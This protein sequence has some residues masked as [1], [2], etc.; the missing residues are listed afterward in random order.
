MKTGWNGYSLLVDVGLQDALSVVEVELQAAVIDAVRRRQQQAV[1]I[2]RLELHG[3]VVGVCR[4]HR[5]DVDA[6]VRRTVVRHYRR[7]CTRVYQLCS[8][9][10]L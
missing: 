2:S 3:Q 10:Q 5:T 6:S 8:P 7:H 4:H 9:A 1:I